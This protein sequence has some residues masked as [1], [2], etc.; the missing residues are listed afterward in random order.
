[1]INDDDYADIIELPHYEPRH[2][3]RMDML[4]RA[5]QFAPFAAVPGHDSAIR[6][7]GAAHA[8]SVDQPT[9]AHSA[10]RPD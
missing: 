7:S 8:G 5:A 3:Q 2:H 6:N 4:A 1:M 9:S 10:T